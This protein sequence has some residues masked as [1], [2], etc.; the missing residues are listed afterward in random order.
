VTICSAYPQLV[1]LAAEMRPDWNTA[2]FEGAVNAARNAG[3]TFE[4][5]AGEAFRMLR[6]PN[7]EPRELRQAARADRPPAPGA[8]ERGLALA[9]EM[10]G[11]DEAEAV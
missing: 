3:W 6:T 4:R 1:A 8:T 9:R 10:L 2:D 5:I 7:A 11:V